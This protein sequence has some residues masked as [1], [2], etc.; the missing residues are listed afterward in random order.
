LKKKKGTDAELANSMSKV[1]GSATPL[2]YGLIAYII[3]L[4]ILVAYAVV[5]DDAINHTNTGFSGNSISLG[6]VFIAYF[7]VYLV[8]FIF[9]AAPALLSSSNWSRG[10][11]K[12]GLIAVAIPEFFMFF[13]AIATMHEQISDC[14]N[15]GEFS[16]C[17]W[18]EL[19]AI[20]VISVSCVAQ[21]IGMIVGSVVASRKR[22][23][24]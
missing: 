17:G 8:R 16:N 2:L 4:P 6:G 24:R 12:G 14:N 18:S 7:L 9:L 13:G 11:L 1:E 5:H 20:A 19:G 10:W 15:G 23:S 22:V 3:L 21:L